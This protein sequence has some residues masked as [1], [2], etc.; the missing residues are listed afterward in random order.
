MKIWMIYKR[1]DNG[2]T[3]SLYAFTNDEKLKKQ[4]LRERKKSLFVVVEKETDKKNYNMLIDKNHRYELKRG[5]LKTKSSSSLYMTNVETVEITITSGEEMDIFLKDN[6]ILLDLGKY[7]D[8]IATNF[9]EDLMIALTELLYYDVLKEWQLPFDVPTFFAGY[10]DIFE[11]KESLLNNSFI[12]DEFGIF[13]YLFGYT[14]SKK[15][16][17]QYDEN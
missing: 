14:I 4:F 9:N 10:H 13:M 2:E 1:P 12:L 15:G 3:P 11:N 8:D 7:T 16:I 17:L 5:R 6:S